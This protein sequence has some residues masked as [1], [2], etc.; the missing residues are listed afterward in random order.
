[1]GE[2]Q[3]IRELNFHHWTHAVD[4]CADAKAD[5]RRL[6]NRRI[7]NPIF[8]E[9]LHESTR[10]TISPAKQRHV[11]THDENPT[12]TR[13]LVT[14]GFPER[15]LDAHLLGRVEWLRVLHRL[16]HW[17]PRHWQKCS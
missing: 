16:S 1:H 15:F 3:E 13:H 12:V 7:Q 2:R 9:F 14:E 5:Q 17:P 10:D 11:L 4:G 6:R 8:P